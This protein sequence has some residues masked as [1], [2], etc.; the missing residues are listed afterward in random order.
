MNMRRFWFCGVLL[1]LMNSASGEGLRLSLLPGNEHG[2]IRVQ[3][4]ETT[5][6]LITLN[7]SSNLLD[8]QIIAVS[9]GSNFTFLDPITP[10]LSQ[11]FYRFDAR[12][13]RTTNDWKNQ[14]Q[15]PSDPF[16]RYQGGAQ[17]WVKFA[18]PLHDPARVFFADSTRFTFHYDF[19]TARL[20][21][22]IGISP[23]EFERISQRNTNRELVVGSVLYPYR[24]NEYGI[25]FVSHDPLPKELVR[26]LFELVKSTIT[27]AEAQPFYIP[28]FEQSAGAQAERAYF[29]SNGISLNSA[30]RWAGGDICYSS[31]WAI[32]QLK[33]FAATNVAGAYADGRLSPNDILIVDGV[34]AELPYVSGLITL[35]PTTAN[36]HVAILAQSYGVP[37][38]YLVSE[39][40]R[41]RVL[42][43][44]NREVALQ[45][46]DAEGACRGLVVALDPPLDP[47][48]RSNLLARKA[49]PEVVFAPKESFGEYIAA[50]ETLVPADIKYFGGKA[51][52]YGVLRRVIPSNSELAI[53][54]S[55]DL[56]DD[57][58][59]QVL[60]NGRTLRLEISNRLAEFTYPPNVGVLQ[61]RLAGIRTLIRTGTFTTNQQ[62]AVT[63]ALRVFDRKR[64]IRFRSST[65]VED[66]DSF[67][68]AGLYDSYSGCLADDQDDDAQ[69]PSVCDET[70]MNERGV[71]RAIGRV[72]ASF[73]N[74][75]AFLER[76]R[77]GVDENQ[78][79][80]ALLVHHSTPD[81]TELANGVATGFW[82]RTALQFSG[83]M[84]TQTGAVSVAN[85]D[86][87]ARPETV[88]ID[89]T[90]NLSPSVQ[91]AEF[92]SLLPLGAH[93]MDWQDDYLELGRL[94][95][96]VAQGYGSVVT[97]GPEMKLDFEYKKV[98]PGRLE[99][100]QVR[101][102]PPTP[103][104]NVPPFILNQPMMFVL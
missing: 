18:I 86:G 27:D 102:I 71:F 59:D 82:K 8:W 16:A 97:N 19:A 67:S 29:E 98:T 55:F 2:W 3:G 14:L 34:P 64:N 99:L 68:G 12:P 83:S 50:T 57:F 28:T 53:A 63:N 26:D 47:T 43:L 15:F 24:G 69:G 70:E 32:G 96:R 54:I 61:T 31:G 10:R 81:E 40:E 72:Y 33:F 17:N 91:V 60:T 41:A 94:L 44:T 62:A 87:T 4:G 75:N 56:W 65:N 25:Q 84:V 66:A 7:A 93:V 78:A 79:G 22:F 9:H 74:S 77:R 36:S 13:L 90:S 95:F 21:P 39:A 6:Q 103:S 104:S 101:Q 88:S 52:N 89:V 51:A 35:T 20:E 58:M 49:V 42:Q 11:R 92:S 38:V 48:V 45:A 85:P 46:G 5:N 23:E 76:L 30:E 1:A 100:K 37:F 80:M 73:Y